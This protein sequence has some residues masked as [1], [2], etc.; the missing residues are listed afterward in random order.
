M[1]TDSLVNSE[2]IRVVLIWDGRHF[3]HLLQ[4]LHSF[5]I[6]LRRKLTTKNETYK[7]IALK[8]IIS[9]QEITWKMKNG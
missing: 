9:V 1:P 8:K 7:N 2:Y 4:I 5:W 3:V 6:H